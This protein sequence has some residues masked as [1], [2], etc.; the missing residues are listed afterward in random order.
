MIRISR[1]LALAL[2]LAACGDSSER[3]EPAAGSLTGVGAVAYINANIWD[4][5][6]VPPLLNASLVVRDGRVE[7]VSTDE[8]PAGAQIIDLGGAWVVPGF[9]NAHGHVSG[10]WAADEVQGEAAMVEGDLALYARYGV[11]TVLSLGGAPAGAFGIRSAQQ[12]PSLNHAR[13]LLAGQQVFSHDP[14]EA[15]AMTQ[16]NIDAGVDWIK[17]RVDDNLGTIEK[18]SWDALEAALQVAKAANIPVATHIFY[19]EDA[20]RLLEM[21][22][23]LIAHSVRDQQVSDEFVQAMLESG[24][25]Y[26]PTLVREV[27]SFVYGERPVFFDDPFFLEAA[28]QSQIDRVS[29]PEFMERMATSPTA[30]VYRRALVQAQENLAILIG[31]GVPIAFGTDSGPAGRF[32]GYF[33]YMELNLMSEAGLTAE[34]ILLS[35]TSV[36]ASCLQLDDVGTLEV[37]KWA[38]FVVLR[39]NPLNDIDAVRSMRS[40]YVAGNA[41]AR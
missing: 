24:V 22:T 17:M 10:R 2:F 30:P 40:V 20:Q 38:D 18:M 36:A 27:V 34:E 16:A 9:I 12:G 13:L 33:E 11:T 39:Q 25:C 14:D 8:A 26:V 3:T 23:N 29:D 28:K 32:P 4:G 31:S 1:L 19:L 21:G 35:A 5:T 41:V 37:G 7:S 15:A 6:G